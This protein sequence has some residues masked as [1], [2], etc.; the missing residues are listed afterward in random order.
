MSDE[1]LKNLLNELEKQYSITIIYSCIMGSVNW[2][3]EYFGSDRDIKGI[4]IRNSIY[5]IMYP[6]NTYDSVIKY[7]TVIDNTEI[8]IEL[9]ELRKSIDL[10]SRSNPSII[11]WF[12]SSRILM[13]KNLRSKCLDI[14]TKLHN[15]KS[16]AHHYYNMLINNLKLHFEG[17]N[18]VKKKKYFFVLI[19]SFYLI[20]LF[21][22]NTCVIEPIFEKLMESTDLPND[23]KMVVVDLVK[24]KKEGHGNE[25]TEKIKIL[26]SWM[27][28]VKNFAEEK[29]FK[30]ELN[31][32]EINSD[33]IKEDKYET[34]SSI[35]GH[36]DKAKRDFTEIRRHQQ[37]SG[38]IKRR[39]FLEAV[40]KVLIVKYLIENPS[41]RT[42]DTVKL[43]IE[44]LKPEDMPENIYSNL[45]YVIKNKSKIV[46]L[47]TKEQDIINYC[48]DSLMTISDKIQEIEKH[49]QYLMKIN[50]QKHYDN[51]LKTLDESIFRNI[52]IQTT[53]EILNL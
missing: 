18:E 51:T 19:P 1:S 47:D 26:D 6:K 42:K 3:L 25:K 20:Q 17:K 14:I 27:M 36:Y 28:S 45:E 15:T 8:E 39:F 48:E 12:Q 33:I 37:E 22:N 29:L 30:K 43:K 2:G 53:K 31:K 9:W 52:L 23:V 32:E 16:L 40:L 46:L 11:E 44:H 10:L 24:S 41:K 38:S 4:F 13:D 34:K 49:N 35:P 50:R 21:K 7:E 5:D